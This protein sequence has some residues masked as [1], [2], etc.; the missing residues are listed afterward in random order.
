MELVTRFPLIEV[1]EN[2]YHTDEKNGMMFEA[3][4]FDKSDRLL[5][6][7]TLGILDKALR[8]EPGGSYFELMEH[9][10]TDYGRGLLEVIEIQYGIKNAQILTY[11]IDKPRKN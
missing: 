6:R 3:A 1:N 2:I 10:L 4:F 5:A 8:L 11:T 9:H 7:V